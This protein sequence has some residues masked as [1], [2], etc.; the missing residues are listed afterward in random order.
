MRKQSAAKNPMKDTLWHYMNPPGA[1]LRQ[2]CRHEWSAPG[3]ED[4]WHVR[5]TAPSPFLRP[6]ARSTHPASDPS[7]RRRG[8][9]SAPEVFTRRKATMEELLTGEKSAPMPRTKKRPMRR[10]PKQPAAMGVIQHALSHLPTQPSAASLRRAEINPVDTR[11]AGCEP[12]TKCI[13]GSLY[14]FRESPCHGLAPRLPL[15]KRC[16]PRRSRPHAASVPSA[17]HR[18]D[19]RQSS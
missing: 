2:P 19:P 11:M 12:V 4:R 17:A 8:V 5:G 1:G 7:S 15:K 3:C 14:M 9:P 16:D 6:A 18:Q 10:N 13:L